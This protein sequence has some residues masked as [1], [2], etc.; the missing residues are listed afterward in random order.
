MVLGRQLR[1][2]M[3]VGAAMASAAAIVYPNINPTIVGMNAS[4]TANG[5]NK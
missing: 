2:L 1:F 5:I 3:I 4:P